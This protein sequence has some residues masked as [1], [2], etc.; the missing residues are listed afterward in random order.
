MYSSIK[1]LKGD[2]VLLRRPVILLLLLLAGMVLGA[3]VYLATRRPVAQ[4]SPSAIAPVRRPPPTST[5]AE[6]VHSIDVARM[7]AHVGKLAGEIG[8]RREGTKAEQAAASYVRQQLTACGYTVTTVPVTLPNG[9]KSM[10]VLAE[11]P[12]ESPRTI[13]IG[14]HLDSH[15]P[16]PGA[17]DN[18]SGV[19]VVLE[20]ARVLRRSRPHC[21]LLFAGF[22]AE[23]YS[24]PGDRFHHFG[25]RVLAKNAALRKRLTGMI[26]LD[27]VGYGTVLHVDNQGRASNRRRDE[28]GA[29]ARAMGLPVRV[30]RSKPQ[31]DHEAFERQCIPVAYLHWE[32]DPAYHRRADTPAH[33]QPERLRRTAELMARTLLNARTR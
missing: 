14:A 18:A 6:T 24:R 8:V 3:A 28:I 32:R 13:L 29:V 2:D 19:A 27:M 31:S 30:R 25:S 5:V 26:S 17:N 4:S 7:Q 20:L 22:G 15:A 1:T 9:L 33:I 16:A 12:G 10:N 23:E 21:T 11:L